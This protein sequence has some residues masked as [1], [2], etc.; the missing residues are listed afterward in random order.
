M[1]KFK[2]QNLK[3]KTDEAVIFGSNDEASLGYDGTDL[4]IDV[5]ILGSAPTKDNH[6]TTK[7]A[8]DVVVTTASGDLDIKINAKADTVHAHALVKYDDT[9]KI[10]ITHEGGMGPTIDKVEIKQA[11]AVVGKWENG[12]FHLNRDVVSNQGVDGI[13]YTFGE[14]EN[15]F[16]TL[17]TELGVITYVA[18]VSGDIMNSIPEPDLEDYYTK[19]E[20]TT[21]SGDIIDYTDIEL[22]G[23]ADT[24]H[25]HTMI[26]GSGAGMGGPW[27]N[28]VVVNEDSIN[29]TFDDVQQTINIQGTGDGK[30]SL[31]LVNGGID[32]KS[33]TI[34][35]GNP[36]GNTVVTEQSLVEYVTSVSGVIVNQIPNNKSVEEF[37]LD[38]DD[39]NNKY[40]D[41]AHTPTVDDEVLVWVEGGIKGLYNSDFN[42]VSGTLLSWNGLNWDGVLEVADVL[43]V[44]YWY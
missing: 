6:L 14:Y 13:S 35:P 12:K 15:A 10:E 33:S 9:N 40:I 38:G 44:L 36:G 2:N 8:V 4:A 29:F 24:S 3:F 16:K 25:S 22:S 31:T 26:S 42:V 43:T 39:I 30:G 11:D 41:L 18:T 5:P 27:A 1:G 23:K 17:P 19:D 21:I 37:T 32:T 34:D 20:I 7:G 28:A